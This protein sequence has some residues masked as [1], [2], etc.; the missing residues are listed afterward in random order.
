MS[1]GLTTV[2]LFAVFGIFI[3]FLV[4]ATVL[5]CSFTPV[6]L[7]IFTIVLA[8]FIVPSILSLIIIR[9]QQYRLWLLQQ[10]SVIQ[11]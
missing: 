6:L 1:I 7:I 10:P 3:L 9:Q 2:V 5:M 4:C 8:L 11:T